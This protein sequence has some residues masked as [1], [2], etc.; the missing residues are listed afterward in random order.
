ML[1]ASEGTHDSCD[2][3]RRLIL[4]H[5][6]GLDEGCGEVGASAVAA[7]GIAV[8]AATAAAAVDRSV[9]VAAAGSDGDCVGNS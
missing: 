6:T 5:R 2:F 1:A 3:Q 7:A 9:G 8:A 4:W